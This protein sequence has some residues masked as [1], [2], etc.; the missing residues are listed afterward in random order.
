[1]ARKYDAARDGWSAPRSAIQWETSQDGTVERCVGA[2]QVG[3]TSV[4]F[5]MK[6]QPPEKHGAYRWRGT[7]GIRNTAGYFLKMEGDLRREAEKRWAEKEAELA[8][9]YPDGVPEPQQK[10]FRRKRAEALNACMAL[11][12]NASEKED[13]QTYLARCAVSLCQKHIDAIRADWQQGGD[14]KAVTL[15]FG[16]MLHGD[17]FMKQF[18]GKSEQYQSQIRKSIE[19]VITFLSRLPMQ[20][21]TA[22]MVKKYAAD[23]GNDESVRKDLKWAARFWNFC[24]EKR[25]HVGGN[26]IA[27]WL[28]RHGGRG[29]VDPEAAMRSASKQVMLTMEEEGRLNDYLETQWQDPMGRALLLCKETGMDAAE[30]AVLQVRH[31]EFQERP[32]RVYLHRTRNYAGSAT[33][34]Y[35]IPLSPFCA[36]QLKRWYDDLTAQ[37]PGRKLDAFYVCGQ[38]QKPT[39]RETINSYCRRTL[40]ELHILRE[41]SDHRQSACG[42]LRDNLAYRLVTYCGLREEPGTVNFLLGRSLAN[43]TTSDHYH[44]FVDPS[45]QEMLYRALAR[46]RRFFCDPEPVC[47]GEGAYPAEDPKQRNIVQIVAAVKAGSTLHLMCGLGLSGTLTVLK[48]ED[49]AG[50]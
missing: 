1:M 24:M 4:A 9:R 25:F 17:S 6:L 7:M 31:L 29:P 2:Y 26:P 11:H 36:A 20:R 13:L 50:P 21:V 35:T 12:S 15:A 30:L 39:D 40:T 28:E 16:W 19:R 47:T 10:A 3:Q 46:D 33:Q 5:R 23:R 37:N 45:G 43:D 8:A 22:A 18:A 27:K 32:L 49:I 34:D 48:P 38:G 41:G 44:N 42:L 14:P